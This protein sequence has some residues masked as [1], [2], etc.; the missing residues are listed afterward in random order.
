[1][2]SIQWKQTNGTNNL[3][4]I[5][6]NYTLNY[7]SFYV[8]LVQKLLLLQTSKTKLSTFYQKVDVWIGPIMLY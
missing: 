8:K 4:L 5:N 6:E 7:I 1:M 2:L 3:D